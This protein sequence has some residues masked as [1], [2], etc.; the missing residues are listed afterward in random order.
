MD[1][2]LTEAEQA[3]LDR[4]LTVSCAS[5]GYK[6]EFSRRDKTEW[7]VLMGLTDKGLIEERS[8]G[9]RGGKR[10]FAV[11]LRAGEWGDTGCAAEIEPGPRKATDVIRKVT[12][13]PKPESRGLSLALTADGG[14]KLA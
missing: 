3:V 4:V 8:A 2:D 6:P 10:F 5:A 1:K 9:P 11:V 7:K 14:V 13:T 12:W